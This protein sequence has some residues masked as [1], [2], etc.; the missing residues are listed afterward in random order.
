MRLA[1]VRDAQKKYDEAEILLQERV[2]ILESHS[3]Q[4]GLS[5]GAALF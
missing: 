1:E 5:P 4:A 2:S 3:N